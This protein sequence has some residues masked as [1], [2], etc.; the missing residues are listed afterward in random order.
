MSLLRIYPKTSS[1]LL[2]GAY[3]PP[4]GGVSVHVKRLKS[5]LKKEGYYVDVFNTAQTEIFK[6]QNIIRLAINILCGSFRI[7]HVHG[8]PYKILRVIELLRKIKKFKLYV[9]DHNSRL[10]AEREYDNK[11]ISFYKKII[12]N[13]DYLVVVGSNILKEYSRYGATLPDNT[14]VHPSFI[15]PDLDEEEDI[16]KTYPRELFEFMLKHK[17]II[18]ASAAE[19]VFYDGV[20]LYGLDM[21]IE[22]TSKL[23][24]QFPNIGFLFALANENKHVEYLNSMKKQIIELGIKDN[25]YFLTGQKEIWPLFRKVNLMIRP[26]Y[27]DGY[28]VSIAEA[29]YF[30]CPAVA[31]NV[32]ERP[33]GTILFK[34]RNLDDIMRKV[35]HILKESLNLQKR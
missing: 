15:A 21:C 18:T 16:L 11:R 27:S 24:C 9:T 1:V 17:P 14:L 19:I 34:S 7:V 6:G 12:R 26:T 25:F 13:L 29:L 30:G 3:P 5:L 2:V 10:F 31:S 23:K 20:D 32:C 4:L 35:M 8:Y 28:G 22:L 33:E